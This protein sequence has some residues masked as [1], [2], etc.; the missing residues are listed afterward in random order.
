[1]IK[2]K[3]TRKDD[4]DCYGFGIDARNVEL[5]KQGK[6][7]IIDLAEMGGK[8]EVMLFYGET[9]GD[10][11]ETIQPFV[12]AKTEVKDMLE[13]FGDEKRAVSDV[14]KVMLKV[15][16]YHVVHTKHGWYTLAPLKKPILRGWTKTEA[17]GWWHCLKHFNRKTKGR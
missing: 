5:L 10:L 1:M 9:T 17:E 8:G 14:E 3:F 6:P 13:D 16:G 2:F 15:L 12:G 11:I 4:L 7:I